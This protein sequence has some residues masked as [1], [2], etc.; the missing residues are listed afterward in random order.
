MVYFLIFVFIFMIRSKYI[1]FYFLKNYF[2]YKKKRRNYVV[3]GGK[4]K[5][6]IRKLGFYCC[7]FC[8]RYGLLNVV[9]FDILYK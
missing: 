2:F 1:L 6:I 4:N 7:L 8:L 3:I 5:G 9:L